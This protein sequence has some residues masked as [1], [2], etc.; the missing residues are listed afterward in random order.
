MKD[1]SS[2]YFTKRMQKKMAL[3]AS[4]K[5]AII[6]APSGYG[7]TTTMRGYLKD[8]AASNDVFWFTAVDEAPAALYRRFCSEIEKIDAR[9]GALMHEIDYPN[10]FTVGEACDALRSIKCNTKT[11]LIIDEFQYL[12]AILPP[13]FLDALL[14]HDKEE[15]HVVIITQALGHNLLSAAAARGALHITASDL[16]MDAAD[17]QRYF[18]FHGADITL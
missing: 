13:P 10:A 14:D 17:I 4:S 2:Y 1:K 16:Q 7:K 6:E 18:Y 15:F 12:S 3:L 5:A 9:A 11:W 8:S